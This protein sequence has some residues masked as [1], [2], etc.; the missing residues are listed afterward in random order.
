MIDIIRELK[1]DEVDNADSV[2][3]LKVG[4]LKNVAGG[5]IIWV[6][7]LDHRRVRITKVVISNPIAEIYR[8]AETF[9]EAQRGERGNM[10]GTMR[11]LDDTEIGKISG[12]TC[13]CGAGSCNTAGSISL[14]NGS[15]FVYWYNCSGD[16]V[17][18]AFY[19]PAR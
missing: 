15:T 4:E 6:T 11:A 19:R 3:E 14:S 5:S 7:Y 18:Y 8:T 2:C 10:V 12:G 16:P 13:P 1:V 17:A 9:Q